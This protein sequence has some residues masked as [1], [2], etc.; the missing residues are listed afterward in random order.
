MEI[1][2]KFSF[3]LK[4]FNFQQIK[5]SGIKLLKQTNIQKS[6]WRRYNP[7]EADTIPNTRIIAKPLKLTISCF[8]NQGAF[9][10]KAKIAT[11][12]SLD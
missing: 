9:P 8:L 4:V 6:Y 12:V 11:V 3:D 10:G 7:S 1:K 5:I 2:K